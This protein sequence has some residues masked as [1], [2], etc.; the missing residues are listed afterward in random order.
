MARTF[1]LTGFFL[2]GFAGA[3]AAAEEPA[4]TPAAATPAAPRGR[5]SRACQPSYNY[6]SGRKPSRECSLGCESPRDGRANSANGGAGHTVS[7]K[8]ECYLVEPAW[9]CRL[10]SCG[11]AVLGTGRS[12]P[13][14]L[15]DR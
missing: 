12:R 13:A 6:D 14:G 4:A 10:P 11:D 9:V 5:D 2:W 8:G 15:P 7:R 1:L 3:A